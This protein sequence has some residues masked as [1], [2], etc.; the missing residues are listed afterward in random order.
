MARKPWYEGPWKR[1]RRE[2]LERDDHKCQIASPGCTRTATE[3]DHILPA[4]LDPTGR[5][6]FDPDNLRATCRWCNLQRNRKATQTASRP[7]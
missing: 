4:A 1:V 5:G 6:W 7:W 3:V 2:I